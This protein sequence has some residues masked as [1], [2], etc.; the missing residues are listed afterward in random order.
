MEFSVFYFNIVNIVGVVLYQ[1]VVNFTKKKLLTL[2]IFCLLALINQT[3][4][5]LLLIY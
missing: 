3:T 4:N 5:Y 2:F 1:L